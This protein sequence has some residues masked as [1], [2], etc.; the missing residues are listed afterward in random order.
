MK[1]SIIKCC[2]KKQYF[3]AGSLAILF[4]VVTCALASRTILA[5][6]AT[7]DPSIG[8][9]NSGS[10]NNE[11]PKGIKD[12]LASSPKSKYYRPG[13][14]YSTYFLEGTDSASGCYVIPFG[15]RIIHS[16]VLG[17]SYVGSGSSGTLGIVDVQLETGNPPLSINPREVVSGM[18]MKANGS[19]GVT[20]AYGG[21][22]A[23][24]DTGKLRTKMTDDPGEC[25]AA[26][27]PSYGCHNHSST[28]KPE[29]CTSSYD[30][31]G[32]VSYRGFKP[33][34]NCHARATSYWDNC[35]MMKAYATARDNRRQ[36][37]SD[38]E[39]RRKYVIA[40]DKWSTD[41]DTFKSCVR[42]SQDGGKG[43]SDPGDP[44]SYVPEPTYVPEPAKE[45]DPPYHYVDRDDEPDKN[46][47]SR[48]GERLYDSV[49]KDD[50]CIPR[51]TC[52]DIDFNFCIERG[53]PSEYWFAEVEATR[54]KPVAQPGEVVNF[55]Y[56]IRLL[57]NDVEARGTTCSGDGH[58]YSYN[59]SHQPGTAQ[60]DIEVHTRTVGVDGNFI[61]PAGHSEVSITVPHVVTQEDV[62]K[63]ILGEVWTDTGSWRCVSP[64]NTTFNVGPGPAIELN[65]NGQLTTRSCKRYASTDTTVHYNWNV[66]MK[67]EHKVNSP[68]WHENKSYDYHSQDQFGGQDEFDTIYA[69]PTDE[70]TF[71]HWAWLQLPCGRSK[72][73]HYDVQCTRNNHEVAFT[74]HSEWL[75]SNSNIPKWPADYL[76]G[77]HHSS[78]L[79]PGDRRVIVEGHV[80]NL[81]A[82]FKV[83]QNEVTRTMCEYL[84][85][86]P[87]SFVPFWIYHDQRGTL[88]GENRSKKTCV[89]F[90]YHYTYEKGPSY[91]RAKKTCTWDG[92][93]P[94]NVVPD[95]QVDKGGI[96]LHAY[97][98]MKEKN[99]D[100]PDDRVLLG[101]DLNFESRTW[102]SHG[103][104]K[105]K[106]YEYHAYVAVVDGDAINGENSR[107]PLVYSNKHGFNN[108]EFNCTVKSRLSSQS[109]KI[110]REKIRGCYELCASGDWD[111]NGKCESNRPSIPWNNDADWQ[112]HM[113]KIPYDGVF[114]PKLFNETKPRPGD[115]ICYWSAISNWSVIDDVSSDSILVSNM[116]CIDVAKQ[117]QLKIL[118]GDSIAG[119]EISSSDY[120]PVNPINGNRGSWSQYGLF[121][122]GEIHRFGSAGFSNAWNVYWRN[123][124]RLSYANDIGLTSKD[125]CKIDNKHLGS[126]GMVS[127]SSPNYKPRIPDVDETKLSL[128]RESTIDLGRD[129]RIQPNKATGIVYKNY[130]KLHIKGKLPDG[131][132]VVIY[133]PSYRSG[134]NTPE[135]DIDDNIEPVH[136]TFNSLSDIPSLTII[137]DNDINIKSNVTNIFGN[138]VTRRGH[139]YTCAEDKNKSSSSDISN[140]K[141]S[142]ELGT[143]QK[144]NNNGLKVQGAL[145]SYDNIVFHRTYGA[146][147]FKESTRSIPSEEVDYTPNTFLLP[148]YQ[149]YK[150]EDKTNFVV[151]TAN[152]MIPR[153]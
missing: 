60:R 97:N 105:T 74:D 5:D 57:N 9:G 24:L 143:T 64:F 137:A 113:V 146:E 109:H 129:S 138:Y 8:S 94:G 110:D 59:T 17:A 43:C 148:Y 12:D 95:D 46:C 134:E 3:F 133:V 20:S 122:N 91:G 22:S 82:P 83:T 62:G 132:K 18:A 28:E 27:I 47:S 80:G 145:I 142:S 85:A 70:V 21:P 139:I 55:T 104:T 44:P 150:F 49:K 89:H 117:P 51:Y 13:D 116:Q 121:A 68:T 36:Y 42:N 93:C 84:S 32:W 4:A 141:I 54:D 26:T 76:I 88:G 81:H 6:F 10:G 25:T 56:T 40:R 115:K 107:G 144:C 63:N 37:L 78:S 90:P 48:V 106:D 45:C 58:T 99:K 123:S 102:L 149:S 53:Y 152:N 100:K 41:D 38:K 128:T 92:S 114:S 66:L 124:C 50:E 147:N 52:G 35:Q 119:G 79:L 151:R 98:T 131:A 67:S 23:T 103:R 130:K 29:Y 34:P 153:Y 61:L 118:G 135:V 140:M 111:G 15:E 65:K 87:G 86:N 16:R 11:V 69:Y 71:R 75:G 31:E 1:K 136:K 73:G 77:E 30:S 14:I 126:F 101:D 120:N 7:Y 127:D 112:K 2:R 125:S 33:Y 39:S 108:S 72:D 96:M 19:D